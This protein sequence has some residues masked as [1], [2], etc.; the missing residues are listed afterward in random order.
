MIIYVYFLK[1]NSNI[2]LENDQLFMMPAA[3]GTES[4]VSAW[5]TATTTFSLS[6]FPFK[7]CFFVVCC[8]FQQKKNSWKEAKKNNKDKS[9]VQSFSFCFL[10]LYFFYFVSQL[11]PLN[12]LS[13]YWMHV[14][15]KS[16]NL[17]S[18]IVWK[19]GTACQL[20][21]SPTKVSTLLLLPLC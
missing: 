19:H 13:L 10:L 21:H 11:S 4:P 12:S 9:L 18:L 3:P 1:R 17:S 16:W 14:C 6:Y 20:H 15:F 5:L 8:C 2:G 7:F